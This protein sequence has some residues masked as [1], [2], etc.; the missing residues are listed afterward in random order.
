M[1]GGAV[2]RGKASRTIGRPAA[3]VPF[4]SALT[5]TPCGGPAPSTALIPV[6]GPLPRATAGPLA[7]RAGV[8]SRS[9]QG[10]GDPSPLLT[11]R[12]LQ[13]RPAGAL[14]LHEEA[15]SHIRF[16]QYSSRHGR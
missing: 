11:L 1:M 7:A 10:V 2:I 8:R 12:P 14:S 3:A 4:F 5:H 6:P 9:L 15:P 16:Y 13:A